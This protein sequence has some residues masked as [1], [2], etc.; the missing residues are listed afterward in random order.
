MRKKSICIIIIFLFM[1]FLFINTGIAEEIIKSE[2]IHIEETDLHLN[3]YEVPILLYHNIMD[4]YDDNM[5]TVH[6]SPAEFEEH[7]LCLFEAGYNTIGFKEYYNYIKYNE[8][9]P[10]KPIIITFDDGYK[11]NYDYAYPVLKELGMKATI[12]IGTAYVNMIE[13]T[14]YPHFTWEEALDMQNSG[15]IDIQ[16]HSHLHR[17]MT[18]IQPLQAY[19]EFALSKYLIEKN[20]GKPCDVFAY[21]YGLYNISVQ[22]LA[23]KL[24]YKVQVGVGDLGVN[25]RED[26]LEKL[27]R[28][29]VFGCMTGEELLQMIENNLNK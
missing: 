24:G 3:D 6:V 20:L 2:H 16:S 17:D 4:N 22:N 19:V 23:M 8:P 14:S 10:K 25:R 18:K 1:F 12:F 7:M 13:E 9:L 27:K 26:G 11:S 29:T 15:V 5:R 28:L 21:P